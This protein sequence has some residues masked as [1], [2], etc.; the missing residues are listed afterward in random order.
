MRHVLFYNGRAVKSMVCLG[1]KTIR[2]AL[3]SDGS[4]TYQVRDF[5]GEST[6]TRIA[7][8][9]DFRQRRKNNGINVL[10]SLRL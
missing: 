7:G 3:C 10:P 4:R 5:A 6:T 9:V 1:V 8:G 2:Q